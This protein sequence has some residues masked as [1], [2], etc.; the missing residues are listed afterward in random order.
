MICSYGETTVGEPELE[1]GINF[2]FTSISLQLGRDDME[3]QLYLIYRNPADK[4][5]RNYWYTVDQKK[6][7]AQFVLE[8]KMGGVDSADIPCNPVFHGKYFVSKR[9]GQPLMEIR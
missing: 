2:F 8:G 1:T 9:T 3:N 6:E 4:Q 7:L 5:A